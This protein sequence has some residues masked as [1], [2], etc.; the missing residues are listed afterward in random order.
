M[1]VENRLH[2][3]CARPHTPPACKPKPMEETWLKPKGSCARSQPIKQ[4]GSQS[5]PSVITTNWAAAPDR[6]RVFTKANAGRDFDWRPRAHP[7]DAV[8]LFRGS[9]KPAFDYFV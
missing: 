2:V 3:A 4:P 7:S 9:A 1:M 6:A 8:A 5:T